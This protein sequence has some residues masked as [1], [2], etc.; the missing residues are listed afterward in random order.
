MKKKI[1]NSFLLILIS[2]NSF[3]QAKDFSLILDGHVKFEGKENPKFLFYTEEGKPFSKTNKIPI[4]IKAIY[5]FDQSKTVYKNSKASIVFSLDIKNKSDGTLGKVNKINI[6]N[7]FNY[8][9][10]ENSNSKKVNI[11][12]FEG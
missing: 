7:I 5:H 4:T 1:S 12:N 9:Q 10:E 2:L 3:S 6:L 8:I 11:K